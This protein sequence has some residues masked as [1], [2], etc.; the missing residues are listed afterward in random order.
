M[1]TGT[2]AVWGAEEGLKAEGCVCWEGRE[3]A[4]GILKVKAHHAWVK[5][6]HNGNI[7]FFKKWKHFAAGE[8]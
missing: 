6:K 8:D 4:K 7:N 3:R 2:M 5:S 1:D